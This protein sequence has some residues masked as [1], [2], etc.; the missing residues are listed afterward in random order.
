M[1]RERVIGCATHAYRHCKFTVGWVAFCLL[2][3][4]AF[5]LYQEVLG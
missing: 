5:V 3:I 2:G 4:A 1:E